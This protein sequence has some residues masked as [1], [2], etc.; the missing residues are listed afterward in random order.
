MLLITEASQMKRSYDELCR[1]DK[2][3]LKIRKI[4][5]MGF[6]STVERTTG[7]QRQVP[8]SVP[9]VGFHNTDTLR[10]PQRDKADESG[11]CD[12]GCLCRWQSLKWVAD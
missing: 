8:M 6:A 10:T 3:H 1:G 11:D 7:T 4:S 5:Q 9:R 12:V 2:G